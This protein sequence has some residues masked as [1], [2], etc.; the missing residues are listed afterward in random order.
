MRV[1][2]TWKLRLTGGASLFGGNSKFRFEL[3][4]PE[5]RILLSFPF[6]GTLGS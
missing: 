2:F 4:P 1:D 3:L 5:A 6:V